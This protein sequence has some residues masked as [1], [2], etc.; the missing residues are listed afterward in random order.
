MCEKKLVIPAPEMKSIR[1]TEECNDLQKEDIE[2]LIDKYFENVEAYVIRYS[3]YS[4]D[5][6]KYK[7]T[8]ITI[9][10]K[11]DIY[12][13][14]ELRIFEEDSELHIWKKKEKFQ[15]RYIKDCNINSSEEKDKREVVES[16]YMLWGTKQKEEED[17]CCIYEERG[18]RFYMPFKISDSDLPL[19]CKIRAYTNQDAEG[20][21]SYEDY[22]FCGIYTK[23]N[24]RVLEDKN[25]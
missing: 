1:S 14:T 9:K 23:D 19:Y 10:N 25:E 2:N 4:L 3:L 15:Y 24:K 7:N 16:F 11:L 22:R 17:F 20:F 13:M 21:F 8:Q 5:I 6:G 12:N 18:M